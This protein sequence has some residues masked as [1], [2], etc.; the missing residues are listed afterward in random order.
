MAYYHQYGS[1]C[2]PYGA[3]YYPYGT[4]YH[5]NCTPKSRKVPRSYIS[6]RKASEYVAAIDFGTTFCSVAYTLKADDE[7]RKLP[8]D[9]HHTRVPNAILIAKESNEVAAFGFRA[10]EK[11]SRLRKG[12]QKGYVY[13]E[14][15][16]MMLYRGQVDQQVNVLECII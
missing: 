15:M 6:F 3:C 5:Q 2:H 11:F 16:K 1:Y 10:Q 7:I 14:R 12:D 13:F 9:G 4:H 8:L